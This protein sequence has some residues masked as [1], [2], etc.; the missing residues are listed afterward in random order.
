MVVKKA[1]VYENE[2]QPKP[3]Q[4]NHNPLWSSETIPDKTSLGF[5]KRIHNVYDKQGFPIGYAIGE[6]PTIA[7]SYRQQRHGR[8]IEIL[9][10]GDSMKKI[11]RQYRNMKDFQWGR[12]RVETGSAWMQIS[13][14]LKKT[15]KDTVFMDIIFENGHGTIQEDS[16]EAD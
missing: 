1:S 11:V 4:F 5:A 9:K 6:H 15:G 8:N 2:S 3:N 12:F 14:K 16:K 7:R 10:V 13:G